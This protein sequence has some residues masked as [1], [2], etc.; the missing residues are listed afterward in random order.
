ME[1]VL[2]RCYTARP[3]GADSVILPTCRPQRSR[4][5]GEQGAS[6]AKL[7]APAVQKRAE[8]HRGRVTQTSALARAL[9]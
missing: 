2:A 4:L 5:P 3:L 8:E 7:Q 1:L 6:R 9:P